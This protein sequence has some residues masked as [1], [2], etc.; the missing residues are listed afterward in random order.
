MSIRLF[1]L[2]FFN[3]FASVSLSNARC[4]AFGFTGRRDVNKAP[5]VCDVKREARRGGIKQSRSERICLVRDRRRRR[6]CAVHLM[7]G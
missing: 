1:S 5:G 3:V 2:S 6:G 7:Q 4:S